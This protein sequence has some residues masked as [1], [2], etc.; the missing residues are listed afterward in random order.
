MVFWLWRLNIGVLLHWQYLRFLTIYDYTNTHLSHYSHIANM[1][2][3]CIVSNMSIVCI[4][5][6]MPIVCIV[7]NMPIVCIVS[8]PKRVIHKR[9]QFTKGGN[10][11][12][13]AIHKGG[14]FTDKA[15]IHLWVPPSSSS[16]L[17][18]PPPNLSTFQPNQTSSDLSTHSTLLFTIPPD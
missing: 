8:N 18:S 11:Q 15:V 16:L 13:R 14:W 9:G 10:S 17:P 3:V 2:I 5:S 1:P 4:V 6:S 12:R 7:S